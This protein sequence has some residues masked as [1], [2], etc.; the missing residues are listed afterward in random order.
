[1]NI[2]FILYISSKFRN[3][4]K[5]H[6]LAK[7]EKDHFQATN[8]SIEY[9]M[10]MWSSESSRAPFY[11]TKLKR[12]NIMNSSTCLDT[13]FWF[14]VISMRNKNPGDPTLPFLKGENYTT[15]YKKGN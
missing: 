9:G 10:Q 1:M 5:Y 4:I 7:Y 8:R 14:E 15:A 3:D 6:E 11:A 2:Q 13:D 12:Y